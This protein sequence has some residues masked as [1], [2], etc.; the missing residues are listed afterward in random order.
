MS[1][2]TSTKFVEPI[3][4]PLAA[5]VRAATTRPANGACTGESL[6]AGKWM[7]PCHRRVAPHGPTGKKPPPAS[8]SLCAMYFAVS[9]MIFFDATS[10]LGSLG[11]S[12]RSPAFT[13]PGSHSG[14]DRWPRSLSMNSLKSNGPGSHLRVVRW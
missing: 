2:R 1:W 7:P 14:N 5:P 8:A 13:V 4:D 6:S 3:G 12:G 9:S 10:G 11:M